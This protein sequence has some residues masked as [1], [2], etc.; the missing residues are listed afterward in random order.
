MH[1]L[2]RLFVVNYMERREYYKKEE[3]QK[4]SNAQK[5]GLKLK[6]E[7][8]RPDPTSGSSNKKQKL[9]RRFVKAVAKELAKSVSFEEPKSSAEDKGKEQEVTRSRVA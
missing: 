2:G 6:H 8:R 5:L 4:L 7:K 1:R 9:D 3:Y